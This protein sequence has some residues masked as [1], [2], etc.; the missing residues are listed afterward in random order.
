MWHK[1]TLRP[2]GGTPRG[3]MQPPL[4]FFLPLRGK[5]RRRR[6]A[7]GSVALTRVCA[8]GL[9]AEA[10]QVCPLTPSWGVDRP[11]VGRGAL[12]GRT[13]GGAVE[14]PA[15][16]RRAAEARPGREAWGRAENPWRPACPPHGRPAQEHPPDSSEHQRGTSV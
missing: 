13:P 14:Q 15:A 10:A 7:S 1:E 11:G 12:P 16:R 8:R 2:E 6:L 3:E 9:G 4:L 5:L